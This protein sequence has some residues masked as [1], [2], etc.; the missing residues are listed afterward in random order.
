VQKTTHFFKHESCGKCTPCREGTFWMMRLLDR[1]LNGKGTSKDID[2]LESV[3]GQIPERTL[4]PLGE[5]AA[6]SV[7]SG[8]RHFRQDFEE[9]VA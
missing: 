2:L 3:A 8:I 5:F 4:C 7:L 6:P 1:I 9:Y